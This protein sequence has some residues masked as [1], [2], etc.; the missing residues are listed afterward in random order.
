MN[1][2]DY[3]SE[4]YEVKD[5]PGVTKKASVIDVLKKKNLLKYGAIIIESDIAEIMSETKDDLSY[6]KWQFVKLQLR[7]IIKSE[8][9]YVSSR[10]RE[11]DLYILLAH[12]MAGFNEQKN[13]CQLRNLR[14][15]TRG[16][17]MIN[18]TLLSKEHQKKLEFEIFRNASFEI[19]MVQKMKERCR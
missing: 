9:F 16:L 15:R 18:H 8:G 1:P 10:G 5:A 2:I 11:N 19:E 12:E 7:E 14:Q 3:E 4:V 6:E 13:K 17:H